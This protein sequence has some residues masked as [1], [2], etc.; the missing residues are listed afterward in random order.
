ML[1]LERYLYGAKGEVLS[2]SQT[3]LGALAAT[4]SHSRAR[5]DQEQRL[6]K[7]QTAMG[8]DALYLLERCQ[9]VAYKL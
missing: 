6:E 3:Q 2:A 7:R 8:S 9:I 1:Y 4:T 5:E